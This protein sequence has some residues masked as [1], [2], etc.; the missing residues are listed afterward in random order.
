M[1]LSTPGKAEITSLDSGNIDEVL[2]KATQ[3]YPLKATSRNCL[4]FWE[5]ITVCFLPEELDKISVALMLRLCLQYGEAWNFIFIIFDLCKYERIVKKKT[6]LFPVYCLYYVF[7]N[8]IFFKIEITSVFHGIWNS[9]QL[10]PKYSHLCEE[11]GPQHDW[12]CQRQGHTV[13]CD[14]MHSAQVPF[15]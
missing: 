6:H 10:L 4:T 9:Q 5:K 1:G 8:Q 14:R 13:M 12:C 2:S 15:N 7:W 11:S 3:F